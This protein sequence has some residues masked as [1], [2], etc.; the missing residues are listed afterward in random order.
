MTRT[1]AAHFDGKFIVPDEPVDLPVGRPLVV[2]LEMASAVPKFAA[3]LDFAA[4]LPDAPND[5]SVRH[6]GQVSD[7]PSEVA[8]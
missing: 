7:P 5:L 3:L 8:P 2:R 1:I 6:D 4:D